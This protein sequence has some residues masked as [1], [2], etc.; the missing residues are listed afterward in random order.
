MSWLELI[1]F[2]LGP[3]PMF[4]WQYAAVLGLLALILVVTRPLRI[5]PRQAGWMYSVVLGLSGYAI[6]ALLH[7]YLPPPSS[8]PIRYDLLFLAGM[9][10][11]HKG[12]LDMVREMV[13]TAGSGQDAALFNFATDV[14]SGQRAEIKIM[15]TMLGKNN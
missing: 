7:L 13:D 6:S 9:L 5:T 4:M 3:I 11:H 12:G 1:R 8:A 14:D 15:Q 10:Q 2:E